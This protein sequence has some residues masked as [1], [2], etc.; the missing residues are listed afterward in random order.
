VFG[1]IAGAVKHFSQ[2]TH[3][4]EIA[5]PGALRLHDAP[6]ALAFYAHAWAS[7][8]HSRVYFDQPARPQARF[9]LDRLLPPRHDP[10]AP[11]P[12]GPQHFYSDLFGIV[13]DR[14]HRRGLLLGFAG[15]R[16]FFGGVE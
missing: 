9:L 14:T 6:G 7:W 3:A 5:P 16:Q 15:Q 12:R 4:P 2:R 13:A 10:A 11:K 8:G 1:R